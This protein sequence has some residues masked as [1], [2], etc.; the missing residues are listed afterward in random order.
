M[1]LGAGETPPDL[2]NPKIRKGGGGAQVVRFAPA[3][4]VTYYIRG[5]E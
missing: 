3:V 4:A 2:K 5:F 1:H